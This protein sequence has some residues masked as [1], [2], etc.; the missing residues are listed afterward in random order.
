M[1]S[2]LAEMPVN[3]S[4][5]TKER[6]EM[7]ALI[8]A[9]HE[10]AAA[11]MRR[12]LSERGRAY[13][14]IDIAPLASAVKGASRAEYALAVLILPAQPQSALSVLADLRAATTATIF[15]VGPT[16]DAKF[17]LRVLRQ[18]ADEYLD[19]ADI[20]SELQTALTKVKALPVADKGDGFVV[21]VMAA[22]GG[23]GASTLCANLG[24]LWAN[25]QAQSALIDMR[26]GEA[27]LEVLLDLRPEYRLAELCRNVRR[28]DQ[29]M[30]RQ[31]LV[32]HSSGVHLLAAPINFQDRNDVTPQGVRQVLGLARSAFPYIAVD[33]ERDLDETQLAVVNE[34][35]LI[36]MM[37]RLDIASLRG[38]RRML[39]A[40]WKAGVS[41]ERVRIV[42]GRYGQPKELP[43]NKVE[44]ALGFSIPFRIPDAPADVNAAVNKG[45]P[46]VLDR[47]RS[48][49]SKSFVKLAT[50]IKDIHAP[51]RTNGRG[52]LASLFRRSVSEH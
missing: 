25:W 27:D 42:A 48:R 23:T 11:E 36:L 40:L 19:Q 50:A 21:G 44:Q 39:D 49:V 33:L 28:L 52:T 46:V 3:G 20:A 34:A 2:L 15:V 29:N 12:V 7:R 51:Q 17:V 35:D 8:I 24:V 37:L 31:S 32:R 45:V 14:P 6:L 22:S 4:H 38:A 41:E 16:S 18:G 1:T 13:E 9:E 10:P 5:T 26:R 43:L 47:P 30:F